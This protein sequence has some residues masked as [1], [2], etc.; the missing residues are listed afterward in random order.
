MPRQ[1]RIEYENAYYHVMNRGRGRQRIFHSDSDYTTFL[2]TISEA[3]ER[4]NLVVH[5][6]CLMGNHYHLLLQTPNANLARGIRHINGVYTQRYNRLKRTDGPLFRGRYKAILVDKD[7]YLLQLSRYIHRNPVE[8][9]SP[10]VEKLE[11]YPWSSY[12]AYLNLTPA[13]DWLHREQTYQMLGIAKKYQGY[14][15]YVESGNDPEIEKF[16]KPGCTATV[17][18]DKNFMQWVKE[19]KIPELTAKEQLKMTVP[20]GLSITQ[21]VQWAAE[22]YQINPLE[23]TQVIKGPGKAGRRER[24][25]AMYLCQ[26][27]GG[28][29]L[30]SIMKKFGLSNVGS[31]SFVTSQVR[32]TRADD[33]EFAHELEQV[34]SFIIKQ[35]T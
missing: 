29:S 32:K 15:A 34:K 4:F 24:K 23:I 3:C 21:I 33:S 13:P 22:H 12:P 7:S 1:P 14:R 18:G 9:A 27:L 19:E 2:R 35:A 26:Q 20:T 8:A 30:A 5:A 28:H 25:I 16:Y 31:V 17:I 6:Y 10:L 11:S